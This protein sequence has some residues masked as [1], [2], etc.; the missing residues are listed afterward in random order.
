MF[1]DIIITNGNHMTDRMEDYRGDLLDRAS[2]ATRLEGFLVSE[3][4]FVDAGL[5]VT[6]CGCYGSGKSW[7]LEHWAEK[8]EKME[9][10]FRFIIRINA[11]VEDYCD[12]PLATISSA[13]SDAMPEADQRSSGWSEVAKDVGWLLAGGLNEVAKSFSGIDV[14]AAGTLAER[15]KRERRIKSHVAQDFFTSFAAKRTILGKVRQTLGQLA[16]SAPVL[17]L[18]DELDR[19][20]PD[21]AIS[22]LETINHVFDVRG[23]SFVL[24]VD[25]EQLQ[26]S[27]EATFGSHCRSV[28]YF[29]KFI[30]REIPLP[31]PDERQW[32]AITKAYVNRFLHAEDVRKC[33]LHLYDRYDMFSDLVSFAMRFSLNLRQIQE[34]FR[35]L[36]H[37]WVDLRKKD[38]DR[39]LK[40]AYGY[41]S[42]LIVFVKVGR[43]DLYN[44][45]HQPMD[46]VGIRKICSEYAVNPRHAFLCLTS[47]CQRGDDNQQFMESL[48]KEFEK[49]PEDSSTLYRNGMRNE[50][51][52]QALGSFA[53]EW[54]FATN[55]MGSIL[56]AIDDLESFSTTS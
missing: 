33:Y 48:L 7:F 23:V 42:A 56:H 45:F 12:E 41:A 9:G 21:Y 51:L 27:A 19:C 6:L 24:A 40:Y 3:A 34:V 30:H 47:G 11:W 18:V 26:A 32:R 39:S 17:I 13:I 1:L 53:Q 14:M 37:L 16:Q 55:P 52:R 49:L 8:L 50:A 15:K 44:C 22:F 5:V 35:I 46:L 28:E 10:P 43:P 31:P 54:N 29:R 20:R 25:R 4:R 2:F 38:N 36:G